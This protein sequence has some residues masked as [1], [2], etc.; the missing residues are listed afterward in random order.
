MRLLT[1][2]VISAD[3]DKGAH[4]KYVIEKM[5]MIRIKVFSFFLSFL[6]QTIAEISF[7]LRSGRG[8][9]MMFSMSG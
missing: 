3:M 5:I 9:R 4:L 2:I 6:Q 7:D 8:N 1:N